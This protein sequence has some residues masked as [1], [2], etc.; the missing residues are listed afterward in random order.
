MLQPHRRWQAE[1]QHSHQQQNEPE[2][3]PILIFNL[4]F[5]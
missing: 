2:L 1:H 5:Y 3:R 4:R